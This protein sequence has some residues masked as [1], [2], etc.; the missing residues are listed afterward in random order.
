MNGQEERL[1]HICLCQQ[2]II[3]GQKTIID[4]LLEIALVHISSEAEELKP[5]TRKINEVA[6]KR[7]EY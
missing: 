5:I 3:E 4:E 2:E 7:A 6:A 1:T